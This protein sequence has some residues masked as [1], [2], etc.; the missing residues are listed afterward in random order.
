MRSAA[1]TNARGREVNLRG[2]AIKQEV[3]QHKLRR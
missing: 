2:M 3:F 1:T